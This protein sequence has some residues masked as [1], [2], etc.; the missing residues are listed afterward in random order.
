MRASIRKNK[1]FFT[2]LELLLVIFLCTIVLGSL[3]MGLPKLLRKERFD[4]EVELL[5]EKIS[6][7]TDVMLEYDT[8]LLLNFLPSES[9]VECVFSSS[10]PL[11]EKTMRTL[12][13]QRMLS[14]IKYVS[15]QTLL[16]SHAEV[17]IP[18]G[19]LSVRGEK[20]AKITL[21][22]YPK[23]IVKGDN[24]SKK[25]EKKICASYPQEAFPPS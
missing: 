17:K 8:D 25:N 16:Y 5:M 24:A 1:R 18:K 4:K 20:S 11:P 13:S 22:G 15:P 19:E 7:G 23:Q 3:G 14:H 12:N 6:L 9:G 10:K 2:L 21:P